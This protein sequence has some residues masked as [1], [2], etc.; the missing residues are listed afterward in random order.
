MVLFLSFLSL[1]I[2]NM[3]RIV[4]YL[5]MQNEQNKT[6]EWNLRGVSLKISELSL[7]QREQG[8]TDTE[9]REL[10]VLSNWIKERYR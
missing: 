3:K 4:L 7:K 5:C 9:Q 6:Q 2:V 10:E 1:R 8:L